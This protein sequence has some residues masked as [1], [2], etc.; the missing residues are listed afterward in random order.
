LENISSWISI[1]DCVTRKSASVRDACKDVSK[2]VSR[3]F[4]LIS[5]P[6][7]SA[8]VLPIQSPLDAT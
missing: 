6:A 3:L 1:T 5:I 2:F 4:N 8:A 7:P